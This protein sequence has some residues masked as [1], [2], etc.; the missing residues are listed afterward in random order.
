MTHALLHQRQQTPASS[1]KLLQRG[2]SLLELMVGITIGLLVVL[3]ALGTTLMTQTS[4]G[5]VSDSAR[6]EQSTNMVMNVI[7]EQIRQAGA[8]NLRTFEF[9]AASVPSGAADATESAQLPVVFDLD[10]A[11]LNGAGP[12]DRKIIIN[13]SDGDGTQSDTITFT[14]AQPPAGAAVAQGINQNCAGDNPIDYPLAAASASGS[15]KQVVN[16]ITITNGSLTCAS[17]GNTAQPLVEN[18]T[19][20]QVRYLRSSGAGVQLLSATEIA[21]TGGDWAG[22]DGVEICLHL[23]GDANKA[24]TAPNAAIK[25]CAGNAIAQDGKLHRVVRNVFNLRNGAAL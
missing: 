11:A 12:N 1:A 5:I 19:E 14:Y 2:V 8:M 4:S 10:F 17:P 16:T 9:A 15:S 3:A 13:G 7:G 22:I 6:L 18:A 21:S 20:F 25:N 24:P 23:T